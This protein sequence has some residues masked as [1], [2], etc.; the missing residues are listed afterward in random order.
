MEWNPTLI[1]ATYLQ[2]SIF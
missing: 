1:A 2:T